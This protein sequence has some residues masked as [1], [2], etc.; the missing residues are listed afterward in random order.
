MSLSESREVVLDIRFSGKR[1]G[2][3]FA[4]HGVSFVEDALCMRRALK[5]CQSWFGS[6]A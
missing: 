2:N 5:F 3:N 4:E 6:G 1:V